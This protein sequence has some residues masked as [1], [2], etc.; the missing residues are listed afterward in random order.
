MVEGCGQ[1]SPCNGIRL[2]Q[3]SY[4]IAT[5]T[6]CAGD[7]DG[8]SIKSVKAF[9]ASSSRGARLLG[10]C[11]GLTLVAAASLIR[12]RINPKISLVSRYKI[13]I[14]SPG[15]DASLTRHT[16]RMP[17]RMQRTAQTGSSGRLMA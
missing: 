11:P 3:C 1:L 2:G 10:V 16:K 5:R 6:G 8:I 7:P 14:F 15:K 9:V 13:P 17:R 12:E 4:S